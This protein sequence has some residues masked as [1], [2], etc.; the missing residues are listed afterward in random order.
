MDLKTGIFSILRTAVGG[1]IGW[2]V[3]RN[4]RDTAP[5]AWVWGKGKG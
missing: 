1:T 5:R 3:Y 4:T 2:Q